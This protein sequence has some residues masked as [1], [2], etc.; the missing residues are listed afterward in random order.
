[1]TKPKKSSQM[2]CQEQEALSQY[3]CI[4]IYGLIETC[5]RAS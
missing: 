3:S 4:I 5:H 1:M 2:Y